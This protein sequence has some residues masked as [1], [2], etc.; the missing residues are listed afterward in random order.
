MCQRLH[1]GGCGKD[2]VRVLE[3]KGLDLA[4]TRM[5]IPPTHF[6]QSLGE[7]TVKQQVAG[8]VGVRTRANVEHADEGAPKRLP[9]PHSMRSQILRGNLTDVGARTQDQGADQP[10]WRQSTARLGDLVELV[11]KARAVRMHAITQEVVDALDLEQIGVDVIEQERVQDLAEHVGR[12]WKLSVLNR[13]SA[14]HLRGGKSDD[15]KSIHPEMDRRSH[16][17][18]QAETAVAVNLVSDLYG[19]KNQRNCGRSENVVLTDLRPPNQ[20]VETQALGDSDSGRRVDEDDR[21]T[22]ADV[23]GADGECAKLL[24]SNVLAELPPVDVAS[25]ECRQRRWI[26]YAPRL[27]TAAEQ[28]PV[29]S[30][31]LPQPKTEDVSELEPRPQRHESS[32]PAWDVVKVRRDERSVDGSDARARD[33]IDLGWSAGHVSKLVEDVLEHTDFVSPPRAA[34]GEYQA[35]TTQ[36]RSSSLKLIR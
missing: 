25:D 26:E 24:G 4:A 23:C 35:K 22:G 21:L 30:R 34:A 18:V 9:E 20:G 10:A 19:R 5:C 3:E 1:S 7:A 2:R 16:R 12:T 33:Q 11:Q 31:R 14:G 17:S 28:H 27:A 6:D 8:Q 36:C 29:E 32:D 13:T 15:E